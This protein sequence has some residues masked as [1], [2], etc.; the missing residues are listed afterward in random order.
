MFCEVS[1]IKLNSRLEICSN[2]NK[3]GEKYMYTLHYTTE[4]F[5][6]P[7]CNQRKKF[8]SYIKSLWNIGAK[9]ATNLK[10]Y[11]YLCDKKSKSLHIIS[12][13]FFWISQINSYSEC[14]ILLSEVFRE[15]CSN[16]L[17]L[18]SFYNYAEQNQKFLFNKKFFEE[19]IGITNSKEEVIIPTF[20]FQKEKYEKDILS[21]K[22]LIAKLIKCRDKIYAHFDKKYYIGNGSIKTL[23]ISELQLLLD[24]FSASYNNLCFTYDR[25]LRVFDPVSV[26]DVRHTVNAVDYFIKYKKELFLMERNNKR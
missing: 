9:V 20:Q 11:N 24:T 17:N 12:P 19:K 25:I 23:G 26:E 2:F 10:V 7:N 22:E 16:S 5:G 18:Q 21:K 1:T 15:S 6:D 3:K 13:S 8:E 14:V 4:D